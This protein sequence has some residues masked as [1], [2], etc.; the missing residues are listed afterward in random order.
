VPM[1]SCWKDGV[2]QADRPMCSI[3]SSSA[4]K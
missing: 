2:M 4:I 1:Y 3:W